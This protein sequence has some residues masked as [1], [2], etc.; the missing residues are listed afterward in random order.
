MTDFLRTEQSPKFIVVS[1]GVCSS[2][3]KGVTCSSIGAVL[4]AHGYKVTAVKIDPYLNVDAG[5]MSPFE[6][7]EVFV[8]DDGG[9]VDLDLGNY[10]RNMDLH[11]SR[12]N[13]IT[14]GKIYQSVIDKERQGKY[15]GKT[16]QMVPHITDETISWLQRV[17]NTCTDGTGEK[18]QICMI[19]LGGT[20]GDIESMIFLEALRMLRFK[21]GAGNFCLIHCC[22][23]PN[24]SGQKTKP[25]QHTVRT[26]SGLG[27]QP[28][29][30]VCRCEERVVTSTKQKISKTCIVPTQSILSV[31][32]VNNL[33]HVPGLLEDEGI[34]P[35]L[36]AILRLD[37]L[38]KGYSED[39]KHLTKLRTMADWR[40]LAKDKDEANEVVRIAVVGKYTDKNKQDMGDTYM[41][42]INALDHAAV[43]TKR[44]L[45]VVWVNS[46]DL[47]LKG[48]DEVHKMAQKCV[49]T[50][51]GVLIPGGFG[52]RGIEGKIRAITYAREGQI[53]LLGICMGMQTA[54]MEFARNV[55]G[56]EGATSEEFWDKKHPPVQPPLVVEY[57][58]EVSKIA[59]GASMILGSKKV[60]LD[61]DSTASKL[62]GGVKEIT[63]RH[64]H[65]YEVSLKYH[66]TLQQ[67]GLKFVG[68]DTTGNRVE[69]IELDPAKHDHPYFLCTQYHPE[70]KS[71]PGCPSPPFLGLLLAA[72]D[73][74]GDA[75]GHCA[76]MRHYSPSVAKDTCATEEADDGTDEEADPTTP[77]TESPMLSFTTP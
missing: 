53:P 15:L 52:D 14:T 48:D 46:R 67:H 11:L 34:I 69:V 5:L 71:R 29:I 57:M 33:Y 24:M 9:E 19:E 25:T 17:A 10:E 13:N 75:L 2:L 54:V 41:S 61:P 32:N 1:G 51:H 72:G 36:T 23:I 40:N 28:D 68:K 45:Q 66:D 8:L 77:T 47:E 65:R 70:Y 76:S 26:L 21:V 31:H 62:Y 63:E 16:V 56:V 4:K 3:G 74:L 42:V 50:A 7:G 38:P 49:E 37:Q 35:L 44:K 18:P 6:H 55:C 39:S 12:I 64:R 20:V 27:L 43:Y 30:I 58:P 22:L 60:I 59:T 73:Q